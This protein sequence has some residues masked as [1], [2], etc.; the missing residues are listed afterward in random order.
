MFVGHLALGLVAKRFEPKISLG[1]W[2][3]AVML[4]D[5]LCFGFLIAGIEHFDVE[6]GGAGK[7]FVAATFF[8]AYSHSLLM[9]A[10]WAALFAAVYFLRRRYARGAWLLFA[11]VLS[12][13]PLDFIS[14]NP[15]MA[16]APGTSTAYGM[17]LWNSIPATMIIEGGFWLFAIIL[18]VRATH[19][20]KR[21]A[22]YALWSVIALLTLTW[23][24]NITKGIGPN[25]V[26]AGING[27][28]FFSLVVAWAY[29]MNRLRP[30]QGE[31]A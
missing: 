11:A 29:W 6:P 23:Y 5:L 18:Y 24:G 20:K 26:R 25:P 13:W 30:V 17:G 8:F 2:T 9:N 28:I 16:L 3:L 1:A 7:R 4:A 21:V 12:H 15:D 27:L 31:M 22:N 19:P 10:I 14:H